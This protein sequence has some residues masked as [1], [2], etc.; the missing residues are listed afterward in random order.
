[1]T[2]EGVDL[3]SKVADPPSLPTSSIVGIVSVLFLRLVSPQRVVSLHKR[4]HLSMHPHPRSPHMP[5][6]H[7]P[8]HPNYFRYLQNAPKLVGDCGVRRRHRH[9]PLV[10]QALDVPQAPLHGHGRHL[11]APACL[12]RKLLQKHVCR[13]DKFGFSRAAASETLHQGHGS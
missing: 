5:P 13:V 6:P 9:D 11:H 10:L 8:P 7:L 3:A 1:M 2:K 4:S 12:R